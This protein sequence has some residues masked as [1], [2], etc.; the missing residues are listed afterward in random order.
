MHENKEEL[1]KIYDPDNDA[2]FEKHVFYL[3][4]G[5]F[6]QTER[7]GRPFE[8][9][10][11]G[12]LTIPTK[13][14]G[15]YFVATY[16]AKV[17]HAEDGYDLSKAEED[18]ALRYMLSED[19]REGIQ[20]KTD[21]KGISGHIFISQNIDES[22]MGKIGNNV[23]ENFEEYTGDRGAPVIFLEYRALLE[24]YKLSQDHWRA[25]GDSRIWGGFHQFVIDA[26]TDEKTTEKGS[27][28][29]FDLDSYSEVRQ[30]LLNR[31]NSFDQDQLEYYPG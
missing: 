17:S 21:D 8:S 23:K 10:P 30:K 16:D 1:N 7:W 3:L 4:K 11:D 15:D 27:Y 13:D 9:E 20:N 25:L 14:S 2:Y 28:V 31:I 29:H 26:L 24:L 5:L 6:T 22:D 18:K 12:L 19:A